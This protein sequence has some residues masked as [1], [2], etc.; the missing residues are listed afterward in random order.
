MRL[1]ARDRATATRCIHPLRSSGC[2]MSEPSFRGWCVA[3][4]L[5]AG[6]SRL[7][8]SAIGVRK[9][10]MRLDAIGPHELGD[11]G[12]GE[13]FADRRFALPGRVVPVACRRYG[14]GVED[15]AGFD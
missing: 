6:I 13:Q 10:V 2:F 5:L 8:R 7:S 14:M 12:I 11:D 4:G 9:E 3:L 15:P 1:P